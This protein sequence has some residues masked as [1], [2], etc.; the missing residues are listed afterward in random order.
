MRIYDIISE[1]D[2]REFMKR[3]G[4]T[5]AATA[6]TLAF[7]SML[8]TTAWPKDLPQNFNFMDQ[9]L[10]DKVLKDPKYQEFKL[11]GK[12]FLELIQQMKKKQELRQ[13]TKR[14]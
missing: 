6:G 12:D 11:M 4:K 14:Y 3:M 5:A 2:R 7:G 10:S 13:K 8:P 9:F 1:N